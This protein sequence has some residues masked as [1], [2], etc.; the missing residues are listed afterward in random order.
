M[1]ILYTDNYIF[2][3]T[4]LKCVGKKW[5]E[6][7][8][9]RGVGQKISGPAW[10]EGKIKLANYNIWSA[11]LINKNNFFC[12][13]IK[14]MWKYFKKSNISPTLLLAFIFIH[15]HCNIEMFSLLAVNLSS[16]TLF[17]FMF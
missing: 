2:V 14:I 15:G 11:F 3:K 1:L 10:W 7:K 8:K 17:N 13:S 4:F 16:F 9:K 12:K 6:E 5:R